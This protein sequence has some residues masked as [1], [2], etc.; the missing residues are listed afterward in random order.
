MH[1]ICVV[2]FSSRNHFSLWVLWLEHLSDSYWIQP[3]HQY[4]Q[5]IPCSWPT[6]SSGC[7]FC[8][9]TAVGTIFCTTPSTP[10]HSF[11]RSFTL[12]LRALLSLPLSLPLLF[13]Q[14]YS[15]AYMWNNILCW[16]L[17][18][19]LVVQSQTNHNRWKYTRWIEFNDRLQLWYM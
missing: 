12:L 13:V 7:S 5:Y 4:V 9:R 8:L 17:F 2:S 3:E 16:S 6:F 18:A 14:K 15:A 19:V 10:V 11:Y 1:Q